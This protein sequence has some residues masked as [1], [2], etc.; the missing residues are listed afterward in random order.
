MSD[1]A[2]VDQHGLTPADHARIVEWWR[3]SQYPGVH[4]VQ[5][6]IKG[7]APRNSFTLP[8]DVVNALGDGDPETAGSV[9][10]S[11]FGLAPFT[12]GDPRVIDP[13]VVRD[14]GHGSHAAGLRV[15]RKFVAMLRRQGAPYRIEQPDG[16]FAER[17]ITAGRTR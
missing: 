17:V 12:D 16:H 13:D 5:P 9:L 4:Y 8:D 6:P 15:L 3:Q 14:L 2:Q 10:H 7:R 1:D 11:M